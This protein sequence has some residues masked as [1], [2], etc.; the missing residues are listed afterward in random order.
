MLGEGQAFSKDG[1]RGVSG[2]PVYH[3]LPVAVGTVKCR[4]IGVVEE[5]RSPVGADSSQGGL[6][7]LG[8]VVKCRYAAAGPSGLGELG[9]GQGPGDGGL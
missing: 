6:Q 5:G 1:L 2:K 7:E 9:P 3:R 8:R 4:D